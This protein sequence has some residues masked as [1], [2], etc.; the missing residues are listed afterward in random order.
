MRGVSVYVCENI[1]PLNH[2]EF[3]TVFLPEYLIVFFF[4]LFYVHIHYGNICEKNKHL[5]CG[6]I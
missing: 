3:L 1:L 5:V 4:F 6:F 2:T